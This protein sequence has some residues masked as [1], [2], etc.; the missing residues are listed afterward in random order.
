MDAHTGSEIVLRSNCCLKDV[1]LEDVATL[2]GKY[3]P[4][5]RET[6]LSMGPKTTRRTRGSSERDMVGTLFY[7]CPETP[8]L[9]F[10]LFYLFRKLFD[11]IGKLSDSIII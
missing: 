3:D 4:R 9:V 2:L 8:E 11:G 6:L 10:E 1:S 5:R 7:L